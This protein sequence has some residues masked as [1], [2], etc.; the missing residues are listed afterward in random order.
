MSKSMMITKATQ[1]LRD[2]GTLSSFRMVPIHDS[3]P[4]I[5]AEF[6][7]S[8]NV[9]VL[10]NKSIKDELRSI[11]KSDKSG[12]PIPLKTGGYE[13]EKRLLSDYFELHINDMEGIV[14]FINIMAVNADKTNIFMPFISQIKPITAKDAMEAPKAIIMP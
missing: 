6:D 5:A 12:Q 7:I 2:G 10:L 9:L 4:F 8:N 1:V 3:C 14:D 11:A 13:I